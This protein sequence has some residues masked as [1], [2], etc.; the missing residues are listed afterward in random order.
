VG[1]PVAGEYSREQMGPLCEPRV[2]SEPVLKSN[3]LVHLP[4]KTQKLE[5][6]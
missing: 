1:S 2:V 3:L 6:N 4:L 5:P